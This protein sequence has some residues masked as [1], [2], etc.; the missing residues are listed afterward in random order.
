MDSEK[1]KRPDNDQPPHKWKKTKG[2]GSYCCVVGCRSNSLR[3][4]GWFSFHKFPKQNKDQAEAWSRAIKR[5]DARGNP[6]SP[7]PY[8][9]I[10]CHHFFKGKASHEKNHPGYIPSIFPTDHVP[11]KT[12]VDMRRFVRARRRLKPKEAT[13][14]RNKKTQ[15]ALKK[16]FSFT[17]SLSPFL[18]V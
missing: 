7:S 16:F 18:C 13:C 12:D 9:V 5:V 17:H 1:R 4:A 14:V 11:S 2:T 8:S 15:V 3:D 6:W 10:C